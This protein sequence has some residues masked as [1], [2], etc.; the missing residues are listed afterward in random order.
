MGVDCRKSI[1]KVHQRT[2]VEIGAHPLVVLPEDGPGDDVSG[3]ELSHRVVLIHEPPTVG[4][5]EDRP[6][7]PQGL[8]QQGHRVLARKERG[9]MEL[10]EFEIGQPGPHPACHRDSIAGYTRRVG[11]S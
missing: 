1:G 6:L 11:G 3:G 4:I 5:D 10:D 9:R 8:G 2:S 7:A